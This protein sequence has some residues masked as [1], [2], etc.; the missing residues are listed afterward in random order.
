MDVSKITSLFTTST[1]GENDSANK[2]RELVIEF[3]SNNQIEYQLYCQ[4]EI[5]GKMW[6]NF[7]E[8]WNNVVI[9][10]SKKCNINYTMFRYIKRGGRNYHYDGDLLFYNGKILVFTKPIEYKKGANNI[11]GLPQF[12]SLQAK[13]PLFPETSPSYPSYYY[14]NYIDRYLDKDTSIH[15]KKPELSE[16]LKRV[17]SNEI[18][19]PGKK[20]SHPF[21]VQLKERDIPELFKREKD[22]VVH[23]SI[24]DYLTTYGET[25]DIDAYSK[26]LKSTQEN[27]LYV[28]WNNETFHLDEFYPEEFEN[29]TYHGIKNG[30]IIQLKTG[31][32]MYDLYLRWRNRQG[33]LNPAWQISMKRNKP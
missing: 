8:K 27:K 25:I 19:N 22:L 26:K 9:A 6:C 32:T 11:G 5:Y 1:R 33:V 3:I 23:T 31:N 16:Y 4:D 7:G 2:D 14:N 15:I 28:L 10:I 20:N 21:F 12:L 29:I 24:S 30:N 13:S 18:A 17:Q